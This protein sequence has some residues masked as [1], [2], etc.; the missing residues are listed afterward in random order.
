MDGL[1]TD[2][3]EREIATSVK[4]GA[5]IYTIQSGV[6]PMKNVFDIFS[7][8][9]LVIFFLFIYVCILN[10]KAASWLKHRLQS[11]TEK[12]LN[13]L[14]ET[15]CVTQAK[16]FCSWKLQFLSYEEQGSPY[17]LPKGFTKIKWDSANRM[18]STVPGI[19]KSVIK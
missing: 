16:L 18:F 5:Q 3:K 12:L 15:S 19:W 1:S 8:W 10:I 6:K 13:P 14:P 7:F 9:F 4:P 11:Q 17:L 2:R